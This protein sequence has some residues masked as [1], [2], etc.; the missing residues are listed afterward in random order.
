MRHPHNAEIAATDADQGFERFLRECLDDALLPGHVSG[1]RDM[2]IGDGRTPAVVPRHELDLIVRCDEGRFVIE[3]KAWHGEVG[4]EAVVVFLAKILDF[5][6]AATFE[7]LGPI[8]AG[9]IALNGFSDAALRVMFTCG[10]IPF[11]KRA[12]HLA[13]RYVDDLLGAAASESK[14][15]GWPVLDRSL[16]ENRA[17]LTPY[18]AQEG[19]AI[20]QTFL[21]DSDSAVVDLEGIRRAAEMFDESRTAHLQA[22]NC[23]RQFKEAIGPG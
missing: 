6:S 10:L 13:F 19:K 18:L 22:M 5:M 14:K 4:K 20:S 21:F 16:R 17:A 8:F 1:V 2:G 3:A 9:F 7:P 12:E 11:T 15:R 23:Y